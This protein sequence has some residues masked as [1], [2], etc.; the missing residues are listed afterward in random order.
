MATRNLRVL[1]VTALIVAGIAPA[2]APLMAQTTPTPTLQIQ[3]AVEPL[4]PENITMR[5]DGYESDASAVGW[6]PS[7]L[8]KDFWSYEVLGVKSIDRTGAFNTGPY[9]LFAKI[10]PVAAGMTGNVNDSLSRIPR[11]FYAGLG[12]PVIDSMLWV[13]AG[14]R[15]L[16]GG[17]FINSSELALSGTVTPVKGLTASLTLANLTSNNGHPVQ[18]MTYGAYRLLDWVTLYGNLGYD[19]SDT[20]LGR[21][22]FGAGLGASI[23]LLENKLVLS[24]SADL[25]RSV[26]KIGGELGLGAIAGGTI[27]DLGDGSGYSGGVAFGRITSNYDMLGALTPPPPPDYTPIERRQ[28]LGWAPKRAYIPVGIDYKRD[29]RDADRNVDALVSPCDATA[30]GRFDR[31]SDLVRTLSNAGPVYTGLRDELKKISPNPDNIYNA[32]SRKYYSQSVRGATDLQSGDTV[33]LFARGGGTIGIRSVDAS[34]FP[35]VSVIFQVT[36]SSGHNISGLGSNDFAFRD[37]TLKI[38]SVKPIDSTLNVPVDVAMIIDLSGSMSEE[39]AAVRSNVETFVSSMVSRGINARIGGVLYGSI[40]YDTLHPTSDVERFKQ[41]VAPASAIGNDEITM[42]AVKAATEMNFRPNAQRIFIL[43]TDDWAVQDNS[44]LTEGDLV[45]LLWN[46]RAKLYSIISP[47][48]N[49]GAVMTRL[50][51]GKEFNIQGSFTPILDEIGK[52]ISTT[53]QLVYEAR[54]EAPKVTIAR[55]RVLDETGRPASATISFGNYGSQPLAVQTNPATGEFET[56]IAEGR[57]Y[58]VSIAGGRYLPLAEQLD[59]S[60][61]KKGDTVVRNFT[62][63]L[64]PTTLAGRIV[65]E[66]GRPVPGEVRID[67]AATL[68][69]IGTV[70]TDSTGDFATNLKEGRSYRLTPAA[71]GYIPTPAELDASGVEKGTALRQD[72]KVISIETAIATGATFKLKNIFFEYDKWELN[73]DSFSELDRMVALMNEYPVIH[74]EVGAHTDAKGSDSYNQTLSEKRA[75]AVADYIVS[76]GIDPSRLVSRGY[77]KSMPVATNDTE[78]GRAL[79]RRVEFKLVK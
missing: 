37:S 77:G 54:Q 26:F 1:F 7:L 38:V 3:S 44:R 30:D 8:G 52:D 76:K 14:M 59:L 43:I 66:N 64:P 21:K 58:Q 33:S 32:I 34:A 51:L 31:P 15:W 23:G 56:E 67:D 62:V 78:E 12:V 29:T 69:R 41:F 60:A 63:M 49:N 45:S 50:T 18:L 35:R 57:P 20:L 25:A 65:D 9:G 42:L 16:D 74:A 47:C 17:G 70:G 13:G 40:I 73:P 19:G 5:H 46:T 48:K 22:A 10:G 39:I 53:Y 71:T 27:A 79:N 2:A 28:N 72:L 6:N 24:G 36:D 11:Q 61:T 55:G 75:K 68:E 4:R